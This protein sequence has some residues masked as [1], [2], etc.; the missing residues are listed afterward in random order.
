M[1]ELIL[2]SFHMPK[3]Q[4]SGTIRDQ[5]RGMESCRR[6]EPRE[7][8]VLGVPTSHLQ[9]G[10]NRPSIRQPSLLKRTLGDPYDVRPH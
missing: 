5:Q 9:E 4:L 10:C 6:S 2:S 8:K 7:Q 1:E 3:T